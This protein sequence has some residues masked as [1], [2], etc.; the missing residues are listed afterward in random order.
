MRT[1]TILFAVLSGLPSTGLMAHGVIIDTK[2][3]P[4]A[5]IL[6]SSYSLSQPLKG[7]NVMIYSPST[8]ENPWLTG[9][10]DKNGNFAFVPDSEGDWVFDVDDQKGHREKAT[11]VVTGEFFLIEPAGAE[12]T[13]EGN[14]SGMVKGKG[15]KIVTGLSLIFGLTGIFYGYRSGQM[16]DK[17]HNRP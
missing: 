9:T 7:A 14:S 13:Q 4:P 8:P 3:Q 1:L 15:Y 10:T 16:A 11:I 12:S 5:V 6:N 17:R 2:M